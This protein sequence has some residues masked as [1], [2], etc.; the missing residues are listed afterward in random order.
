M[1]H[2]DYDSRYAVGRPVNA[3]PD[4]ADFVAQD[5]AEAVAVVDELLGLAAGL[6]AANA[7]AEAVSDANEA[8][9]E[10]AAMAR[11]AALDAVIDAEAARK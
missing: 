2:V 7:E 4:H 5:F 6:A 8:I 9:T 3:S 11:E 1:N 10:A